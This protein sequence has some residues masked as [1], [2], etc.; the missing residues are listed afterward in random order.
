MDKVFE[1]VG[2]FV[3][4]ALLFAIPILTGVSFALKWD[5]GICAFLCLLMVTEYLLVCFAATYD[6]IVAG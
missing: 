4:T 5:G 1:T 6:T 3:L 2:I